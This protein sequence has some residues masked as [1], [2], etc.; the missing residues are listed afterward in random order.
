MKTYI[1]LLQCL[2]LSGI[3]A[4]FLFSLH[5]KKFVF[6]YASQNTNLPM[7]KKELPHNFPLQVLVGSKTLRSG[8]FPTS[9]CPE[10]ILLSQ[11]LL[12][13]IETLKLGEKSSKVA[14]D[15]SLCS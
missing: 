6:K 1:S 13:G 15:H 12:W 11:F 14:T 4:L 9:C 5:L 10:S 7:K 3:L 8:D 2:F